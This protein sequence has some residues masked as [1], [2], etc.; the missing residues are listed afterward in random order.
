MAVWCTLIMA[1]LV[2]GAFAGMV[3]TKDDEQ[4]FGVLLILILLGP[5]IV[6]LAMGVGVMDRRLPNTIA[7]WI[8]VVWNGLILGGF[9][10]L[11]IIGTMKG[12]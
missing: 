6:G 12:S 8:A 4:A 2:T 9:I 3:R 1:L 10:L 7:M 5:S 11:M